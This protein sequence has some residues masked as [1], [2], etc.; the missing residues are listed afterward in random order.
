MT[1]TIDVAERMKII[2]ARI[3]EGRD[4]YAGRLDAWHSLGAVSGEFQTWK[5]M[6]EAAK[7]DF[8]VVK[9]QLAFQNNPVDAWGTFRIDQEIPKGTAGKAV[10]VKAEGKDY[11]L[12]F[13]GTVGQDYQ[14]IQHTS[15]FELLDHLVGQIDGA[16]YETMGTLDF[17]RTVWGQVDPNISIRVGDDVSDVLL[18]FHTSHDGSK[19]FDIYESLLRHV[20]K[21]TLRAGSLKRLAASL[22]VRHTR[23]AQTRIT[24]LKAEIEEI[25]HAALSMQDRLTWLSQRSVPKESM[26]TI[27]NRLFPPTK[28]DDGADVSSGRRDNILASVL[29]R[30]EDNDGNAFPEQRGSAYNLLNSITGYV[31]HDRSTKADGRAQSAVFGSGDRLKSNALDII[32]AESEKMPLMRSAQRGVVVD[33]ADLGLNVP[34]VL[35]N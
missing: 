2:A 8:E 17:G 6:V 27:L 23:N 7:A 4:S 16:H 10:K 26:L 19:A 29:A 25:K 21:N 33:F 35:K 20:C 32:V 9:L 12:T 34:G 18:S 13:L 28:N 15:G 31:D 1:P 14:V 30:Y 11:Y 22:R 5:Q 3:N 24:G